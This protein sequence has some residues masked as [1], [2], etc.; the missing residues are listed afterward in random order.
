MILHFSYPYTVTW[1]RGLL[2]IGLAV[3]VGIGWMWLD[4]RS[5]GVALIGAFNEAL[6]GEESFR[7]P[8]GEPLRASIVQRIDDPLLDQPVDATELPDGSLLVALKLGALVHLDPGSG[9]IRELLDFRSQVRVSLEQGVLA[10]AAH[11]NFGRAG[12]GRVYFTY[13]ESED[14]KT[15]LES[16]RLDPVTLDQVEPAQVLLSFSHYNV[17]HNA[18]DLEFTAAGTLLLSTGDSGGTGDPEQ[19]AQDAAS[20][21]GKVLEI[22]V[23][24]SPVVVSVRAV[25]LRNPWRAALEPATGALWITDVG[26]NC[27]EEVS[28]LDTDAANRQV[29]FGWPILEGEKCYEALTCTAPQEYSPPLTS[30]VHANRRCSIIGAAFTEDHFMFGDYCTGELFAIPTSASPGTE[31]TAILWDG[32]PPLIQPGALYSGP[33][34]RVWI[35]DQRKSVLLEV[36][37]QP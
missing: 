2:V 24:S 7:T 37:I 32:E 36:L 19:S 13:I 4:A 1:R 10:I 16:V 34:G 29:N 18:A 5:R 30:Y 8:A 20:L 12:E 3:G 35:L 14:G 31:P 22:D 9:E 28:V 23:E 11:P 21:L 6:C 27:I 15:H 33:S 26:Q 17:N 25:G